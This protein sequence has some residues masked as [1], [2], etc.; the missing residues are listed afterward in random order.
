MA[1]IVSFHAHPD[2]ESVLCGGSLARA[3]RAGHR[4]VV[5]TATDGRRGEC[6]AG[7]LGAGETLVERRAQELRAAAAL[8]GVH[9]LVGLGHVDSGMR[10][11]ADNQVPGSLWT[12]DVE[13]V[14]R[15]LTAVL[16]EESA[17]VLTIYD[18]HGTYGHPDHI[19]VHRAGR[20]AAEIV[21]TPFVFEAT[22]NRDRVLAA[23][24]GSATGAAVDGLD[25][26]PGLPDADLTTRVDVRDLAEIK[27]SA[28]AAHRS[29]YGPDHFFLAPPLEQFAE[30]FGREWFRQLPTAHGVA[31]T[32]DLMA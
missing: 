11:T 18:P 8:L 4:V 32:T 7:L 24:A 20:R 25:E 16:V 22:L 13:A 17:E 21:G 19:Q 30:R 26:T 2:D 12:C 31:R 3:A 15:E 9:R 10:R 6:P 14:A 1:T 28:I 27:R 23:S 5:V 29:Q